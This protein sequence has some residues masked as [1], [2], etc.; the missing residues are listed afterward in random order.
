VPGVNVY[1][2]TGL[3]KIAHGGKTH[4]W[5]AGYGVWGKPE[6]VVVVFMEKPVTAEV[7]PLN[8]R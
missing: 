3:L 5:F 4:A 7:C 1:G 6:I 2:K 8:R